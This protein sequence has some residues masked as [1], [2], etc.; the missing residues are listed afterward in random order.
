[1]SDQPEDPTHRAIRELGHSQTQI[2]NRL[3]ACEALL[4]SLVL[5][6]EPAAVAGVLEE[7][8]QALDRLA[9]QLPP[10]LQ[11]P[12]LW[13]GFA[14]ALTDRQRVEGPAPGPLRPG[15]ED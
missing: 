13:Q 10:R 5:R 12:Q 15:G 9:T 6:L 11:M 14:A 2:L 1:M 7:Y 8:E 4:H 3:L